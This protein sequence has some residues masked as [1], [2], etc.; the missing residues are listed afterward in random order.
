MFATS[1]LGLLVDPE[2]EGELFLRNIGYLLAHYTELY[3]SE[4]VELFM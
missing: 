4:Y 1:L 3:I 2:D